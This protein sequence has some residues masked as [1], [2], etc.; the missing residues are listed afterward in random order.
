MSTIQD[1]F[2]RA[3]GGVGANWTDTSATA[4]WSIASNQAKVNTG[5]YQEMKYTGASPIGPSQLVT[6][7]VLNSGSGG[8]APQ[9]WARYTGSGGTKC[10]YRASFDY[11]TGNAALYQTT[12]DA[13]TTL[14]SSISFSTTLN[15]Y[16]GIRAIGNTI[17]LVLDG[18][19]LTSVTDATWAGVTG[20]GAIGL[21]NPANDFRC[22]PFTLY[23]PVAVLSNN[24]GF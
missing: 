6:L 12:N 14:A 21:Y 4:L 11:A 9:I 24:G 8:R 22:G 2:V 15:K 20:T 23:T 17:S 13:D 19:I 7:Q 18:A 5:N 3:D 1:T 10:G 16:P